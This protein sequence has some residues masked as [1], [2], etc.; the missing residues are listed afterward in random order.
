MKISSKIIGDVKGYLSRAKQAFTRLETAIQAAA[1]AAIGG[2]I[3]SLWSEYHSAGRLV[4]DA[5]HIAEMKAHFLRGAVI[6]VVFWLRTA[7]ALKKTIEAQA[8]AAASTPPAGP[9]Q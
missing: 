6:A 2:G 1:T 8:S 3:D 7:P 5:T 9:A 4:F